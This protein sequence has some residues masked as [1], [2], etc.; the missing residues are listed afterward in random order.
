ML[1]SRLAKRDFAGSTL[2]RKLWMKVFQ[3]IGLVFLRPNAY[4]EWRYQMGT[5]APDWPVNCP[6]LVPAQA[7]DRSR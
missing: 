6:Y 7:C 4:T 1:F 2:Q 5:A 3:R